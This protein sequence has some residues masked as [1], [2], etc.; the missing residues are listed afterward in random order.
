MKIAKNGSPGSA[1]CGANCTATRKLAYNELKTTAMIKKHLSE[2]GVETRTF[3]DTTGVVG[4][5]SGDQQGPTLAL[6]ADMDALAMEELNEV[7]YR[8]QIPGRMHACGHDAHVTILL[9]VAKQI[10]GANMAA[11]F[12]GNLKF[13]FQPA[14]EG[15]AGAKC[16]IDHGVLENP[17]VDWVIGLHAFP[18][19]DTGQAGFYKAQSHASTDRFE[20]VI[21]GVGS[22]GGRPH[23]GTDPILAAGHFITAVQSVISRNLDPLDAGVIS[24]GRLK[25]GEAANVIPQQAEMSG[26]IRALTPEVRQQLHDRLKA[27]CRGLEEGFGVQCRLDIVEG[28]PSC[29]NN[30]AVSAFAFQAARDL[31]G[32]GNAFYLSPTTGGEDFA[33]YAQQR[34]AAIMRL[35]C[36]N[37]AKGI[38]HP[39]HSP[40][41]DI[42]EDMLI[43]GVD[44]FVEIVRRYLVYKSAT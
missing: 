35:G 34:P 20:L 40:Y 5:I 19:G 14:E 25:A 30:E 15:G 41:F 9:G 4:L 38:V 37:Q 3:D 13:I 44:L 26:T 31:F 7:D 1:T 39:L 10:M 11:A 21:Q 36:R 12:K 16:L 22:H 23:Q 27:I 2:M 18:E 28:Y 32:E 6:R 24:I 43:S 33:Y 17:Y 29:I 42:D 8:S